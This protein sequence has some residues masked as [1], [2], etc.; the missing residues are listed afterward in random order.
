MPPSGARW[1]GAAAGS[2]T[3]VEREVVAALLA[4]GL[5]P[6]EIVDGGADL[7]A[8]PLSGADCVHRVPDRQQRLKRNHHLVILGVVADQHQNLSGH[9]TPPHRSE[10]NPDRA[11]AGSPAMA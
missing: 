7:L 5:I 2:E 8:L 6:F 10:W 3:A 4:V 1:A 11:L 9:D